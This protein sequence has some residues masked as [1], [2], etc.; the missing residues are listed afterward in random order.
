MRLPHQRK[1]LNK[2]V[3]VHAQRG[4]ELATSD[5]TSHSHTNNRYEKAARR[6]FYIG[7]KLL[8]LKLELCIFS[9]STL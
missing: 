7:I 1:K 2:H 8:C 9:A 3:D 6:K 4:L 5:F